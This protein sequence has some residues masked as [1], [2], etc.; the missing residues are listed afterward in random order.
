MNQTDPDFDW[1][2]A[3]AKCSPTD[4]LL[5]LESQTEEDIKKRNDLLTDSEKKYHVRFHIQRDLNQFSVWTLRD[6]E[7]LGYAIFR[8]DREGIRVGWDSYAL[9]RW[10]MQTQS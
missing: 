5:Q 1:I 6:S 2:T 7:R 9:E 3:R 4:V 10:R 8:A